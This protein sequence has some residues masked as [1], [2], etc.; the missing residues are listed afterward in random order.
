MKF[1]AVLLMVEELPAAKTPSTN[2]EHAVV[3][4]VLSVTVKLNVAV[5]L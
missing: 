4:A 1:V 2:N 3:E 5:E